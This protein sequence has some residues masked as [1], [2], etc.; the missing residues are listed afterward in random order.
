MPVCTRARVCVCVGGGGGGVG[1]LT[2]LAAGVDLIGASFQRIQL[3]AS[4]I[5]L[6][7]IGLNSGADWTRSSY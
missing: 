5:S 7:F 3:P 2:V 4:R 6:A 1:I